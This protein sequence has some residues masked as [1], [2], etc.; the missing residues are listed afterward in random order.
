MFARHKLAR[1]VGVVGAALVL[2]HVILG[3]A[4]MPATGAVAGVVL[5]AAVGLYLL[6]ARRLEST[7]DRPSD[8]RR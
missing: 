3:P 2:A 6:I 8:H 7:S 4:V 1:A 5:L